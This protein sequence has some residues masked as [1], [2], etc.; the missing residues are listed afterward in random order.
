MPCKGIANRQQ[1]NR[2]E[3]ATIGGVPKR[4]IR[5]RH[6]QQTPFHINHSEISLQYL[7]RRVYVCIHWVLQLGDECRRQM[8]C[9]HVCCTLCVCIGMVM[10]RNPMISIG[11]I[12]IWLNIARLR[13]RLRLPG[14]PFQHDMLK[15][16]SVHLIQYDSDRATIKYLLYYSLHIM[17]LYSSVAMD[18]AVVW[19]AI[20]CNFFFCYLV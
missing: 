2:R 9:V 6:R 14:P 11:K 15:S 20:W 3:W 18:D 19:A 7:S 17:L 10:P 4:Y 1:W 8:C 12:I 5:H 16:K 13:G